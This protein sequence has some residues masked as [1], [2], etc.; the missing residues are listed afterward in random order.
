MS[1]LQDSN[2]TDAFDDTM[3]VIAD[4]SNPSIRAGVTSAKRL[5]TDSV[6]TNSGQ[7]YLSSNQ[8]YG[9]AVDV[10][11][12]SG[13]TNNNVVLFRNPVGSGKNVYIY[14]IFAG[15]TVTNV[16]VEFKVFSSPTVTANGSAVTIGSRFVNNGA[17]A[18]SM[19]VNTLPTISAQGT[20]VAV[21]MFGHNTDSVI[22]SEGFSFGVAPGGTI[23]ITANP[24]SNNRNVAIEISWAEV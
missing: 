3:I 2:A 23:L 17:P 16:G 15:C 9:I 21:A 8:M 12:A 14:R 22:L 20:A 11:A 4:E 10:N 19:L 6:V 13:S 24:S 1:G 18:S 7:N 5:K